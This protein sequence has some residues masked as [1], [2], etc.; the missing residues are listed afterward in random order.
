VEKYSRGLV[1]LS[2]L[3]KRWG[4]GERRGDEIPQNLPLCNA[5]RN[6]WETV[7]C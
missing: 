1:L 6:D 2:F 3:P 5:L 4:I 7:V